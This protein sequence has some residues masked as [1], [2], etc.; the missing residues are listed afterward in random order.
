MSH[1]PNTFT[2]IK[3]LLF[4]ISL[5]SI[6]FSVKAQTPDLSATLAQL[7]QTDLFR[8]C[9]DFRSNLEQQT[10]QVAMQPNLTADQRNQLRLTYTGVYEKYDAFL[11]AVKQD[12]VNPQRTQ[13]ITQNPNGEAQQYASLYAAVKTEYDT[14][15]TPLVQQLSGGGK[16]ILDDLKAMARSA[17]TQL[18]SQAVTVVT[19][20][21][22]QKLT[23]NATLPVVNQEFYNP[24][25]LKL[26]SELDIPETTA[27]GNSAPSNSHPAS[28]QPLP[29]M[30]QQAIII[31]PPT[32]SSLTGS[33]AFVQLVGGQE[34]PMSFEQRTG[35][36]IEVVTDEPT[37]VVV[38]DQSF[39]TLQAYPVGTR[40]RM[41]VQNEGFTYV[42]ALN[43]DGVKLLHPRV[44]TRLSG[45]DIE[46]TQEATA[47][48]GSVVVPANGAFTITPSKTGVEYPSDDMALLLSKSELVVEEL[49]EKLNAVTGSLSERI[50]QVFGANQINPADAGVRAEGNRFMFNAGNSP[51][52]VLPL[53]FRIRK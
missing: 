13:A 47:S 40:F 42:L 11:K 45:K 9:A 2:M 52:N 18:A 3:Q 27:M 30:Q 34:Q 36:D 6:S 24:L 1:V 53:V 29:E 5:I 38:K 28:Y 33:V 22:Q 8:E 4:Y 51:Q 16:G 26:W 50:T 12:L 31:P 25:R 46:V 15:Y 32:V 44:Q 7:R 19:T 49:L 39:S 14:Q 21:I 35:K 41:M 37:N 20:R 23:I 43:S 10:R 17:F 48:V